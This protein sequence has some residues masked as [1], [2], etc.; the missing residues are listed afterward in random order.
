LIDK[1]SG[2]KHDPTRSAPDYRNRDNN[3]IYEMNSLAAPGVR[4]PSAQIAAAQRAEA[5]YVVSFSCI[6]AL[7]ESIANAIT[8]QMQNTTLGTV[9][10]MEISFGG[11]LLNCCPRAD[12]EGQLR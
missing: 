12:C 1:E 7:A 8:I 5:R 2:T 9:N 11:E 10:F 3:R 4:K 6:A